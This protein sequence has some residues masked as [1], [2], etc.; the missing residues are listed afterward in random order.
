MFSQSTQLEM[1]DRFHVFVEVA[2]DRPQSSV[3]M[4]LES[5]EKSSKKHFSVVGAQSP[6]TPARGAYQAERSMK[7]VLEF[8][9]LDPKKHE[10]LLYIEDALV[11]PFLEHLA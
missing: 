3:G 6:A 2:Y 10:Y 5:R 7:R 11:L 8:R 1:K 4:V 9:D